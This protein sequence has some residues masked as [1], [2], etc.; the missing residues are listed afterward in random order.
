MELDSILQI[1]F[2]I[3]A[4]LIAI[5]A[6]WFAWHT[7]QGKSSSML[8]LNPKIHT[9]GPYCTDIPL[10]RNVLSQRTRSSPLPSY[11]D[12]PLSGNRY[13]R[14]RRIM[15][16][17]DTFGHFALNDLPHLPTTQQNGRVFDVVDR[18]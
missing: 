15:F 9:I 14:T 11:Y 5:F 3:T 8:G 17:E 13:F 4:T 16:V 2:G 1:C 18:R 12:Q 6:L 10:A 7:A